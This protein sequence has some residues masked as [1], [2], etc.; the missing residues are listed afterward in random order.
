[1]D[2]W[3]MLHTLFSSASRAHVIDLKRQV[4]AASKGS[5]TISEYLQQLRR[6]ADELAFAGAP[7]SN[8]ELVSAVINGLGSDFNPVVAAI[9]TSSRL[10]SFSFANL[11][12]ILLSHE[13]LL[14]SQ[15][16][17]LATS[18]PVAFNTSRGYGNRGRFP[19]NNNNRSSSAILPTPSF[20]KTDQKQVSGT[21]YKPPSNSPKAP[22]QICT[23]PGHGAKLCYFRYKPDPEWKPNPRHQAYNAQIQSQQ[24]STEWILDSGASNHVTSDLNNL[25]SFYAY[26][27]EDNLQI[28]NGMGLKICH[29][30]S[31]YLS[32]SPSTIKLCDVLHVPNFSKN[33]ISLSRLLLDN[34]SLTIHF[35]NSSCMIKDHHTMSTILQL[36]SHHGLFSLDLSHPL[37]QAFLGARASSSIW[38]SRLGHPSS[39]TTSNTLSFCNNCALAKAHKLPFSISSSSTSFPLELVHSDVWGPSPIVSFHGFRYYVTFV[40]DFS[41]F[42]WIYFLK[43]KSD[44][45]HVFT[46]FKAQVENILGTSI[47]VLRTDGGTEFKKISAQFPTILH[48]TSCPYTPQQNGVAERKHRH[49][50]EL[51][52]ATMSQA[53]IPTKFW[54]EIFSSIVYLINRLPSQNKSIPYKILFH[55]DPDYLFLKVIGC[56]CFPLTR[57]LNDHKLQPR[58]KH[59]VF[60][61]YA[62]AQKGYK[63]LHIPSNRV[64]ISRHVQFDESTF[65]FAD[66][67]SDLPLITP[68]NFGAQLLCLQPRGLVP[69]PGINSTHNDSPSTVQESSHDHFTSAQDYP[70]ATITQHDATTPLSNNTPPDQNSHGPL[71]LDHQIAIP[72]PSISNPT[73]T[74][75]STSIPIPTHAHTMITRSKDNSRKPK[76]FPEFIAFHA[77]ME[78]EP[79]SFTKANVDPAWQQAMAAEIDALARNKTWSLVPP[80]VEQKIVGC[81]WVFKI[82]RKQDGSVERYKARLV[83]KGFHQQ[84]GVDFMETYSPVVRPSTIRLALTVAVASN[85]TIRQLDVHNAFLHGDLVEKVY[86]SQPQGF[87]D[88]AHPNYVCELHKSLY[89]LKQ[90]PRA[91]FQKLSTSLTSLGF[92]SSKYDPSLFVS[93][94]NG[95]TLLIL[96][97]VDDIIITGNNHTAVQSCISQLQQDFALKDL[98]P[99]HF[100]LGIEAKQTVQGLQL[101]Q[102]KYILDLLTKLSMVN[103]KPSPTPMATTCSLM[104]SDSE[105]FDDPHMYRSVV[106]A[107]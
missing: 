29:I 26:N 79:T 5:S 80:P 35:S 51:S 84:P 67:Q 12:G 40:D 68:E 96:V 45:P 21:N 92:S 81:K 34:P 44:V 74:P 3:K 13:A 10:E 66:Q 86:M 17:S 99:L 53:H 39:S 18:A 88:Q 11:R 24:P 59:C 78:T 6:L 63:C 93:H 82:K 54:D 22:C 83:A 89:G 91:W 95:I 85:W 7:L 105:P 2:L 38:H 65:P 16:D 9:T 71:F 46:L 25:S 60:M 23:K 42:T 28:G 4:A 36:H 49:I 61:G 98:G 1:M 15:A 48:Q 97:Y 55:K 37:P 31:T 107:L 101:T 47:K 14:K 30:G 75:A 41:R 64:Y 62:L 57:P 76:Y 27:G 50:V 102:T 106:G 19:N 52:I 73:T 94:Q 90:A 72:T 70:D 33:L 77:A 43:Q 8:D 104:K 32:L 103:A 69:D 100:F 87:I 56:S 20:P 58:A